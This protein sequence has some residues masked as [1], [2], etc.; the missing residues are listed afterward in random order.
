MIY[1]ALVFVV[2]CIIGELI[3]NYTFFKYL[4]TYFK[5]TEHMLENENNNNDL[6]MGFHISI[7]KGL[8]E[9]FVIYLCL[10]LA[11][12]QILIVY[13]A[14]KI[15][16]RINLPQSDT[17]KIKNDYFLIGNFGSIFIAVLYYKIYILLR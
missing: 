6:F 1:N 4:K 12:S 13:G 3:M 11:I 15:G 9:R 14:L 5:V 2:I 17:L 16:T 8:L 10:V 7:F